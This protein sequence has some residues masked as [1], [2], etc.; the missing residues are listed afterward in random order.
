MLF[1]PILLHLAMTVV[2][3][4][5][6]VIRNPTGISLETPLTIAYRYFPL[7][8]GGSIGQIVQSALGFS[9]VPDSP[10]HPT[11]HAE[12]FVGLALSVVG[13]DNFLSGPPPTDQRSDS[14]REGSGFKFTTGT[15]SDAGHVYY[16]VEP[17][18]V[19]PFEPVYQVLDQPL[20]TTP[21]SHCL[22]RTS[23]AGGDA[24]PMFGP[25]EKIV[26]SQHD[27]KRRLSEE[28]TCGY[29]V[30]LL[31]LLPEYFTPRL[32]RL[33][34]G[35]PLFSRTTDIGLGFLL[36]VVRWKIVQLYLFSMPRILLF[37]FC[38][39]PLRYIGEVLLP[40][41]VF[42]EI[43][44]LVYYIPAQDALHARVAYYM[45][46]LLLMAC[47]AVAVSITALIPDRDRAREMA[48]PAED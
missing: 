39:L 6:Q 44:L 28:G 13:L 26:N 40:N 47:E 8:L 42:G 21:V 17:N 31:D 10:I 19:E 1:I 20:D 45:E 2:V 9:H 15:P 43:C 5:H 22:P 12:A 14:E 29:S 34:R 48:I 36:H 7:L 38:T 3:L 33:I 32:N 24:R 35:S 4:M 37:I 11:Q 18:A 41:H 23:A 46:E 27:G 30:W 16:F 25:T